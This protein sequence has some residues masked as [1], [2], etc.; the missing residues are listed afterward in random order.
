MLES[1]FYFGELSSDGIMSFDPDDYCLENLTLS[2]GIE[3]RRGDR[4]SLV[5]ELAKSELNLFSPY[6]L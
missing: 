6:D 3:F 4:E 2:P 5:L 1:S